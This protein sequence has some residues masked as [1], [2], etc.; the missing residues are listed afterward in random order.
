MPALML[1]GGCHAFPFI[2]IA[3]EGCVLVGV[4]AVAQRP[5][6]FEGEDHPLR[7]RPRGL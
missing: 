5:Y 6:L 1:N 3:I 2:A 7:D 4:L